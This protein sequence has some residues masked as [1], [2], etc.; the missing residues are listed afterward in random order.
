MKKIAYS[1]LIIRTAQ[2]LS[3]ENFRAGDLNSSC[4]GIS[5]QDDIST[6]RR[7]LE[8]VLGPSLGEGDKNAHEWRLIDK[9]GNCV[10]VYDSQ[11][12]SVEAGNLNP[13]NPN[14]EYRWHVGAANKNIANDAINWLRLMGA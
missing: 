9:E 12:G 2:I 8:S 4:S 7:K 13:I 11:P 3:K 14:L 5:Y 10:T 1:N 6:N